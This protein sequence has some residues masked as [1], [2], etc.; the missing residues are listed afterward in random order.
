[1]QK[2]LLLVVCLVCLLITACQKKQEPLPD[3]EIASMSVSARKINDG[4]TLDIAAV[5]FK[6]A[7][8]VAT[9]FEQ[10]EVWISEE[11]SGYSNMKLSSTTTS[12]TVKLENLKADKTY[13]VAVKGL[14]NGVKSEFSKPIMFTT[15]S[16]K[17]LETLLELPNGWFMSSSDKSPYLAYVDASTGEVTL[18][19]WKDKSKKVIFR[20]SASKSYQI[21]GFYSEGTLLVL[22]TTRERER[23]YD[24]YDFLSDKI[25][26]IKMPPGARIW[27]CAFS[28]DGFKMAYTDYNKTGLFIYDTV[29][30]NVRLYSNEAFYDF[31]WSR[32]GKNIDQI[33][34]KPN[35]SSDTREVVRW[36]LA[37][38]GKTPAK[39]FEWPDNIQWTSF[40][41]KD[42][43]VL[44]ASYVSNNADLWIYELKTGK[45]W[46]ISDVA[47]FGWLSDK[48]FFVNANKTGN[49]TSWKTYKYTMP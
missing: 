14:K 10:A 34:T 38:S 19:N 42:D 32:D 11:A 37:D 18:Q 8:P 40:S 25:I 28:P 7:N 17:P 46:Q 16:I 23:A 45:T 15:S 35:S 36:D 44:F 43:Y 3:D 9:T 27:N 49:E 47:N 22:E 2:S 30:E 26:E 48:E 5:T 4:V 1:M 6:N 33:R 21:K 20:N 24:Y 29:I 31:D 39:L 13:F 41:P 12:R